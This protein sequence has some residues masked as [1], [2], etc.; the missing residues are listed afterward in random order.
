MVPFSRRAAPSTTAATPVPADREAHTP[1][2][3][4]GFGSTPAWPRMRSAS[5]WPSTSR[6]RGMSVTPTRS[7]PSTRLGP[8]QLPPV[9]AA[10]EPVHGGVQLGRLRVVARVA[11]R[12]RP[13]QRVGASGRTP[14]GAHRGSIGL[15]SRSGT[16]TIRCSC[17]QPAAGAAR[18]GE[19]RG[20]QRTDHRSPRIATLRRC[21]PAT[22]AR[23]SLRPARAP[24][25]A[26]RQRPA[27]VA[28]PLRDRGGLGGV[29][30]HLAVLDRP[31]RCDRPADG[32]LDP[33]AAGA[34][35]RHPA[36][37]RDGHRTLRAGSGPDRRR[38]RSAA[39]ARSRDALPAGRLRGRAGRADRTIRSPG[40]G[41][42]GRLLRPGPGPRV[43]RRVDWRDPR[44]GRHRHRAVLDGAGHP[45]ADHEGR[46]TAR[47]PG[48]QG[49]DEPRRLGR[50]RAG[51][52]HGDPAR[53]RR[54]GAGDR[55]DHHVRTDRA[56]GDPAV[57]AAP[58]GH[59]EDVLR[60]PGRARRPP[61]RPRCG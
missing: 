55:G 38:D 1:Y 53:H 20:L 57:A 4:A 25:S 40:A 13:G 35:G 10:G 23:R 46:W 34:R 48:G 45:A 33:A 24:R 3:A 16:F 27:T 39:R 28:A 54:R 43:L 30:V 37:R 47:H 9:E 44:R 59:L 36:D 58:A 26:S 18:A 17:G 22:S 11:V 6:P 56:R 41:D 21:T 29:V 14:R 51:R 12:Q 32:G 61:G 19:M 50:A 52:G 5:T 2:R 7:R 49:G 15:S 31:V 60:H 42:L 8:A